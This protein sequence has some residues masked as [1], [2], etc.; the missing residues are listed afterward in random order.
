[1]GDFN[2]KVL[3]VARIR[4]KR[5]RPNSCR[6]TH[7]ARILNVTQCNPELTTATADKRSHGQLVRLYFQPIQTGITI[8]YG[9]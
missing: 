2:T 4:Q 8:T 6:L 7:L 9:L 1:M 3:G 5:V